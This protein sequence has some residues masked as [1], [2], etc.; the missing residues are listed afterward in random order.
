M[1]LTPQRTSIGAIFG[2]YGLVMKVQE[3]MWFA[4]TL[5]EEHSIPTNAGQEWEKDQQNFVV[6]GLFE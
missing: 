4:A 5:R 2:P 3:S 6:I 1:I